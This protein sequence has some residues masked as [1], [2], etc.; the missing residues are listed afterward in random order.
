MALSAARKLNFAQGDQISRRHSIRKHYVIC[1]RSLDGHAVKR[2]HQFLESEK[3]TRSGSRKKAFVHGFLPDD[4]R[5]RH[6]DVEFC[7]GRELQLGL[8]KSVSAPG[9]TISQVVGHFFGIRQIDNPAHDKPRNPIGI[10]SPR[11]IVPRRN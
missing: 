8:I 1:L 4:R 11:Q 7:G 3:R 5:M 9:E 6:R 10:H 2:Q